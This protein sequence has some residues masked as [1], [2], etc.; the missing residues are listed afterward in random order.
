MC[1]GD[2]Q[3]ARNLDMLEWRTGAIP[4]GLRQVLDDGGEEMSKSFGYPGYRK[5]PA[6]L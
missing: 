2:R 4:Q 6:D 5:M 3:E 1:P